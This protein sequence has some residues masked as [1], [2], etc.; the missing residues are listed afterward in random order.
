MSFRIGIATAVLAALCTLDG[1]AAGNTTGASPSFMQS[2]LE[3]AT[4]DQERSECAWRNAS[5][6]A[7]GR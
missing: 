2:C 6:M 7:S 5:R 4:T 1:C 3:K